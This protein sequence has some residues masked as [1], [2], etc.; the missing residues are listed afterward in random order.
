MARRNAA[1]PLA[2]S[3]RKTDAPMPIVNPNAAAVDVHSGNHVVCVPADR[4][5]DDVRTF[6]A[7]SCDLL[8]I[9]AWLK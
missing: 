1:K 8:R 6:G 5:A 3:A 9:A 4:A 2:P 7:N